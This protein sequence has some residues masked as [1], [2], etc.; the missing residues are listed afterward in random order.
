M[1]IQKP[2]EAKYYK[3]IE[4]TLF[5][6][7]SI[8]DQTSYILYNRISNFK[9]N[10]DDFKLVTIDIPQHKSEYISYIT[11]Y[12]L[13]YS[14]Y[15]KNLYPDS[16]STD[17]GFSAMID[18]IKSINENLIILYKNYSII[19]AVSYDINDKRRDIIISHIGVLERRKGYG[20]ILMKDIF[21]LADIIK[22]S[23]TVT[24]NG[25]ADDFYHS[26]GMLRLV[27]KPLGIYSIQANNI[28]SIT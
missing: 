24:S 28:R 12:R 15:L 9:I 27:D 20:T 10:S 26:L 3:W 13:E 8:T 5:I 16:Y 14:K 21:S 6:R 2:E 1:G 19:G 22:F 7:R 11:D 4:P 25:Y 17:S 23:I 18:A